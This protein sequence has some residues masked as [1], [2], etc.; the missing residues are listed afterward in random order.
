L[1]KCLGSSEGVCKESH[2]C[3]VYVSFL[4]T[5]CEREHDVMPSDQGERILQ[6]GILAGRRG[7]YR[8]EPLSFT[9]QSY[10]FEITR[11]SVFEL[12]R[13]RTQTETV[14]WSGGDVIR[15][16]HCALGRQGQNAGSED[17]SFEPETGRLIF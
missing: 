13:G 8:F 14:S 9:S 16:G 7:G 12:V 6:S 3:A 4:N 10:N 11:G 2:W 15:R 1:R 17:R 5:R